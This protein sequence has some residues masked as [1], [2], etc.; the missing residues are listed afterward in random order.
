MPQ[1]N[2]RRRQRNEHRLLQT[3][4]CTLQKHAHKHGSHRALSG[5]TARAPHPT[6]AAHHGI[7]QTK[8]P[9][10]REALADHLTPYAPPC[11][12]RVSHTPLRKATLQ[13]QTKELEPRS[14]HHARHMSCAVSMLRPFYILAPRTSA[15]TSTRRYATLALV[16][17]R[18]QSHQRYRRRALSCYIV[19]YPPVIPPATPSP[20]PVG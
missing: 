1:K 15:P 4:L 3:T 11:E 16:F 12:L 5:G 18:S 17:A 7:G 10:R 8:L 14:R 6:R 9:R 13:S 19:P 20:S 2:G